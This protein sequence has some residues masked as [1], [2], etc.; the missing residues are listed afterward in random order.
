MACLENG[1][2]LQLAHLEKANIYQ[3]FPWSGICTLSLCQ[4]ATKA[5]MSM[6]RFL[7]YSPF[8]KGL[9]CKR[10]GDGGWA[11]GCC[12]QCSS[13][14]TPSELATFPLDTQ[15]SYKGPCCMSPEG[16]CSIFSSVLCKKCL[17]L[18]VYGLSE[19]L[20]VLNHS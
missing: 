15:T 20:T 11:V 14:R 10:L 8:C 2:I 18:G 1:P 4:G 12:L 5:A 9:Q 13:Q 3:S 7:I 17:G 19:S 6:V 16:L